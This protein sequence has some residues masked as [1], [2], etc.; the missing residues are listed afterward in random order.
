[1]IILTGKMKVKRIGMLVVNIIKFGENKSHI[2]LKNI[3]KIIFADFFF[4]TENVSS[5][6]L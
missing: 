3:F 5:S 4:K 2:V 6:S 1:M